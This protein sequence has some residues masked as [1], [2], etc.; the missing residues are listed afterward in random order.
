MEKRVQVGRANR[1]RS[2]V[3]LAGLVLFLTVAAGLATAATFTV[4][5]TNDSGAGS[6]R[7]AII[8]AVGAGNPPHTIAF[9]IPGAGVHTI[10]PASALPQLN[11]QATVDGSTQPGY[12]D[13]SPVIEVNGAGAGPGSTALYV[14]QAGSSVR[15]LIINGWGSTGVQVNGANCTVSW[16][17]IGTNATG[18]AMVMNGGAGV[19]LSSGGN[20]VSHNVISGNSTGVWI[21]QVAATGNTV[22]GNYIGTSAAGT[23]AI[24]NFTYGVGIVAGAAANTIGGTTATDRNV[25]S[26]NAWHGVY[27]LTNQN[28]VRGNYI[29]TDAAGAAALGNGGNGVEVNGGSDN[30]IL[31]NV[32]SGHIT[33]PSAGVLITGDVS[34][35]VL[36]GNLVGTNAAGTA[37][38]PNWWGVDIESSFGNTIGGPALSD[39]NV[40]SGNFNNGVRIS[41]AD[42]NI[43]QGNLI[44]TDAAGTAALGNGNQ[45]VRLEN[46][47][48]NLIGGTL[49]GAGN[50]IAGN[51]NLAVIVFGNNNEIRNNTIGANSAHTVALTNGGGVHVYTGTG[52]TISGNTILS[53]TA[54]LAI[55]LNA[56]G[57]W[58][59]DGVTANDSC[60]ADTG[61]NDLQNYPVLASAVA[62]ASSTTIVGTL[63]ST[64]S[65]AYSLEFFAS[66]AC[67]ASGHGAGEQ[68]LG[69]GSVTTDA[70]CN[71]TF[72]VT[73][74]VAVPAGSVVTA[75][76]TD[77]G[78]NTSEFSA[79]IAATTAATPTTTTVVSS[80]NPSLSGAAVTFTATVTGA[81]SSPTGNVTFGD[82]AATLGVVALGGGS[83]TLTTS[84]LTVGSHAIS[85]SYGGDTTNL[86]S[87]AAVLTQVVNDAPAAAVPTLGWAGLGI[88]GLLMA[89]VGVGL[90]ARRAL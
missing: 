19:S 8:D 46:A 15:G 43:V 55:D 38:I 83:A 87:Q 45:G 73:V 32:I 42:T 76:A 86:A 47:N 70:S 39:R 88:L 44:G 74:P 14:N 79:C 23:A 78:G 29:G 12:A 5:N 6:L 68:F 3:P 31:D 10:A 89:L 59:P 24:P 17:F 63:N 49:A 67:H 85:V 28:I 84:T 26:G 77:P 11:T 62:G 13:W 21:S 52:N 71:G 72:A 7:Q 82:G 64:A 2:F 41:G 25:I 53:R 50:V 54:T 69:T 4:T 56:A 37:A 57:T 60:D 30:Q 36:K 9:N 90:L 16:N 61:P 34:G 22:I 81:G 58:P 48:G 27:I 18:T 40:V 20:T 33:Q 1:R 65:T 51:A 35:N 66:P 75:T 80:L